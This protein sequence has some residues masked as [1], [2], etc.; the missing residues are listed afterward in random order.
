[1][2]FKRVVR[3]ERGLISV[4]ELDRRAGKSGVGITALTV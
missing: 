3:L 4:V 1:M 2:R